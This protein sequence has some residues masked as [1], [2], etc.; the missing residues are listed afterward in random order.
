MSKFTL[1]K[2]TF[3]TSKSDKECD[4][5]KYI[6]E[7]TTKEQRESL[8]I[9]DDKLKK[10]IFSGETYLYQ[11]GKEDKKFK[12]KYISLENFEL[13]RMNFFGNQDD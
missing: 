6:M 10:V 4:G 9:D 7:N 1:L 8:G 12:T 2:R 3:P 11:V 13:I 5:Y